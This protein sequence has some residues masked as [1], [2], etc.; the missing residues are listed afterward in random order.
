MAP[1][2]QADAA[3]IDAGLLAKSRRLDGAFDHRLEN[4]LRRNKRRGIER[5]RDLLRIGCHLLKGLRSIKMLAAGDKPDL[6]LFQVDH[7]RSLSRTLN[8]VRSAERR[9]GK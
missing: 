1:G 8:P 9:V 6:E 4:N 3:R 5:C 2:D 7:K